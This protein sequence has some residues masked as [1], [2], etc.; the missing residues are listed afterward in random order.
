MADGYISVV[1]SLNYDILMKQ[2]RLPMQGET[3]TAD[4]VSYEG[5]GKGA[6]QA[7]QCAKLGV[8]TYMIGKVGSDNFGDILLEKL[9]GYGVHTDYVGRSSLN[10]GLGIVHV[11]ND[12]AVY[13]SIITGANFDMT[14]EDIR[15]MEDI[16]F[17]SRIIILQM[18]IPVGIVEMIIKKAR[19]HGVY[20]ILNAAPA[21][22]ISK[23]ALQRVDCLVVNETEASFYAGEEIKDA[24]TAR[25]HAHKLTELTNG[26]VIITLGKNGSI[27]CDGNS[28][29]FIPSVKV[30][31]IETTGA[32]DSYI[33][34]FAYGKY[35]GKSDEE[36]CRFAARIAAVTVTKIGAQGA[37]P[38][39]EEIE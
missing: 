15:Q 28:C 38:Y 36:A 24:E 9:D 14:Q 8:P 12:G 33:G 5:G 18:E 25:Q 30:D 16:I 1:G 34:A 21:K 6:N 31:A 3:Y 7:V 37:M 39:L 19:E 11:L 35:N 13:A 17:N 27:L 2:E 26:T 22:E 29:T 4:S 32:G 10:T 23:E 20:V